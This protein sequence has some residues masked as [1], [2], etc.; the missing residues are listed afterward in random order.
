MGKYILLIIVLFTFVI[1]QAQESTTDCIYSSD[2]FEVKTSVFVNSENRTF[3]SI[4]LYSKDG[5][6]LVSAI[7]A[8]SL[9]DNSSFYFNFYVLDGC[10]TICSGAFQGCSGYYIYIPSSV[11]YLAPDAITSKVTLHSFSGQYSDKGNKFGGIQDGCKEDRDLGIIYAPK[12]DSDA[13]EVSRYNVNGM[14][15]DKPINGVNIL[16][17]SDGTTEKILVK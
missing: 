7:S 1:G 6:I 4:G 3:K 16:Q 9:Y 14:K 10:E 11:Q 2:G 13:I 8:T 5:K 17:M 15:I 12:I